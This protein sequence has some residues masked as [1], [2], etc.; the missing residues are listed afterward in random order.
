MKVIA[1]THSLHKTLQDPMAF[2]HTTHTEGALLCFNTVH[3][4]K[5]SRVGNVFV[6][7]RKSLFHFTHF[8]YCEAPANGKVL[9]FVE[10]LLKIAHDRVFPACYACKAFFR[11]TYTENNNSG[12][13]GDSENF[14]YEDFH[15]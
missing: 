15:S 13:P 8:V 14:L 10:I 4:V 11:K 6:A 2:F 1:I 12:L 9:Q 3:C 7:Q 5:T